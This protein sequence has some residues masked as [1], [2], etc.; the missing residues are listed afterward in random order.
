MNGNVSIELGDA[1]PYLIECVKSWFGKDKLSTEAKARFERLFGMS[2]N[3]ASNIQ[4]I[5]M[6]KPIPIKDIYQPTRLNQSFLSMIPELNED[7]TIINLIR[8][9][10]N[11]I[12]LAGP[13]DGKT[14]LMHWTYI[15]LLKNKEY[16]PILITLR[17]PNS[18][19]DLEK[20]IL[21]IRK[22]NIYSRKKKLILLVD[23]Y[24]EIPLKGR[25]KVSQL[26]SEF[27]SLNIGN[28]YLTCRTHYEIYDIKQDI[29]WIANFN[30]DDRLGFCNSFIKIYGGDSNPSELLNNLD[31]RGFESF[32]RH[33]LMLALVCLLQSIP[34]QE[35]PRTPI[36]LIR[37]AIDILTLRWDESKPLSRPSIIPLDGEER[38]RCLM[39]I[40][41]EMKAIISSNET[42]YEAAR[43]HL[44]LRQ[45]EGVDT[46]I[47][48]KELAQ[49]YGILIPVSLDEWGFVHR[50][51][52]DFLSARYWVECGKFANDVD[53]GFS[54]WNTQSAYAMS[55]IPDATRFLSKAISHNCEMNV[56]NDCLVN[57]A[58][59]NPDII[60][61]SIFKRY[62]KA[63]IGYC[64]YISSQ[65]LEANIDNNYDMFRN[66]SIPF[67]D[68]ILI[69][70]IKDSNKRVSSIIIAYTLFE[71]INRSI[72]MKKHIYEQVL[73]YFRSAQF[74]FV[75]SKGY[76]SIKFILDDIPRY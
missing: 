34:T 74:I 58:V 39:K 54:N 63:M 76:N 75:I 47:F 37:R 20:L 8:S 6:W 46:R 16:I 68:S 22:V 40:A 28:F 2:I 11:A 71:F 15:Q 4:C 57:N 73:N 70:A 33:P 25:K 29:F 66:A 7:V 35:L 36:G 9:N 19:I 27:S 18:I 31:E 65:S 59:F 53:Q 1:V 56:I 3:M 38:V 62:S 67:L 21:D 14:T 44:I 30:N 32:T 61:D 41:Y 50:T 45:I 10:R 42:V 26:L 5:G 48:L 12:I 51:I 60:A 55:L 43:N 69:R 52:Y 23:G 64:H 17:W 24:D 49:W 72:R 13:G